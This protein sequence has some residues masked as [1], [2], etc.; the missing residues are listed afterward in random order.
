[1]VEKRPFKLENWRK[2]KKK[3]YSRS[4]IYTRNEYLAACVCSDNGVRKYYRNFKSFF[5][6]SSDFRTRMRDDFVFKF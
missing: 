2:K 5:K 3:Y 1:M 6:V 4:K